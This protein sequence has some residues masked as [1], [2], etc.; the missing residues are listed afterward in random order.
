LK[1]LF[2]FQKKQVEH[3]QQYHRDIFFLN[4]QDR[5]KHM[6]MHYGKHSGRLANLLKTKS[7][8]EKIQFEI[9]RTLVDC[10]IIVLSCADLLQLNLEDKL[11]EKLGI[12][13]DLSL[14]ELTHAVKESSPTLYELLSSGNETNQVLNMMLEYTAITGELLKVGEDLDHMVGFDRDVIRE[15][16]INILTII[17]ISSLIWKVDLANETTKRWDV[18]VKR[19]VNEGPQ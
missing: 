17:L 13:D 10:F 11:K 14:N 5:F 3:D 16:T 15:Q 1:T 9:Q 19:T 12:D 4:Y 18:L 6:V 8:V 2:E 7:S